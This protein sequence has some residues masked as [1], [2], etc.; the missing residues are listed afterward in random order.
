MNDSTYKD[1]ARYRWIRDLAN[2]RKEYVDEKEDDPWPPSNFLEVSMMLSDE[3]GTFS[4]SVHGEDLDILI[5]AELIK[6]ANNDDNPFGKKK[7]GGL[8]K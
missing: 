7:K 3:L 8:N 6:L 4:S 5:D 2:K 1:A